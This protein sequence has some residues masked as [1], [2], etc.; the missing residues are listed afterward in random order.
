M[1]ISL[2]D[3]SSQ[4]NERV[5]AFLWH[6]WS[7]IGVAGHVRAGDNRIVDPEA[8]LL[9]TT[10]FGRYDSRLLDQSINWL[11]GYG[12]G[13]NL[14]RLQNL[15][16]EWPGLADTRIL[17]T[18]SKTLAQQLAPAE[19]AE[20]RSL[21]RCLDGRPTG[22]FGPGSI[23]GKLGLKR[24]P[25]DLGD[26]RQPPTPR[27][28][29]SLLLTRRYLLGANARAEIMAWLFTP[30]TGNAAAIA[31]STGY[32]FESIQQTLNE[33]EES[34]HILSAR[35]GREKLFHVICQ[36][37]D[38]LVPALANGPESFPRWVD[39]MPVF[40][41]I[42]RFAD[43]LATPGLNKKSE[44]RQGILLCDALDQAMPALTRA[45]HA[46]QMQTTRDMRGAELTQSLIADL[47][48][49]LP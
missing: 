36:D 22:L 12:R 34:G 43:A 14:Q 5:V 45:G 2:T 18:I 19:T 17:A 29:G 39:W 30:D 11:A 8:L 9:A 3:S 47:E 31:R 46:H 35:Q 32:F 6:Q 48:T 33:M 28:G 15:H 37:W 16:R 21:F 4:L 23:F 24:P 38:Y 26:M 42:A 44:S 7:S 25:L 27:S 13:I 40:V 20:A 41:A 49:I 10:R 1:P